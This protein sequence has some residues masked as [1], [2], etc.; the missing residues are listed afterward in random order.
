MDELTHAEIRIIAPL[1]LSH[2]QLDS[3]Q[4]VLYIL[5]QYLSIII[6]NS[7]VDNGQSI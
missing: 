5:G 1:Q 4:L 6:R 7:A 3:I 2:F